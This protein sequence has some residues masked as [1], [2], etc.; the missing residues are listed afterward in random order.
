MPG[1]V[2]G[3]ERAGRHIHVLHRWAKAQPFPEAFQ[4]EMQ[5]ACGR[6]QVGDRLGRCFDG[7]QFG[8]NGEPGS[9]EFRAMDIHDHVVDMLWAAPRQARVE[10]EFSDLGFPL[11]QGSID[12]TAPAQATIPSVMHR[13]YACQKLGV[14][15]EPSPAGEY[16]SWI[17][18]HFDGIVNA[19]H[20]RIQGKP[21]PSGG[22]VLIQ[23]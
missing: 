14:D 16:L 7:F 11:Q 9:T 22:H 21:D 2:S 17:G 6:F 18:N 19:C 8:V 23:L 20:D 15:V 10:N 12:V 4:I 3:H 13:F 5:A 1:C